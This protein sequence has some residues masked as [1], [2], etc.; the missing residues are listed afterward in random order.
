VGFE[1]RT[2]MDGRRELAR[3]VLE[4]ELSLSKACERMGVSRPTGYVWLRRAEAMG[5]E[6]ME[7][8][9]RRPHR[10]ARTTAEG[11]V[12][13]VL[14][15][16][17]QHPSWGAKKLLAAR[18]PEHE[19]MQA[20]ICVRTADRILERHGLVRKREKRP[21]KV[22]SFERRECNE[23]LQ[24]DFK[25]M[26]R[27]PHPYVPFTVVDDRSRYCLS[28]EPL[29]K[30]GVEGVWKVLWG[31]FGEYGVPESILSDNGNCFHSVR[32]RGPSRL[33][34]RLWLLGVRTI[35]GRRRHPQTQGKVERLHR[36]MNEE[37]PVPLREMSLE[38]A[39]EVLPGVVHAYNWERP[40]EALGMRVPGEVYTPSPRPRPQRLPAH[41]LPNSAT[42]RKVDCAGLVSYRGSTYRAGR[43]LAGEHVEIRE[44]RKG[45][46]IYYAGVRIAC[47]HT[48]EV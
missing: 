27:R 8:L 42:K 26:G 33:E 18:W 32:S 20:P 9:T 7:E 6:G 3:V 34:A 35:H 45:E 40:H 13:E 4:G 24:M 39:R 43:G 38:R 41:E 21:A 23:L 11:V 22:G 28:F 46:A 44:D 5:L 2:K 37:T 30:E 36:T 15:L 19:G 31:I 12:A 48:L 25:G 14:A 1:E 29:A 17:R 16:K 10:M 47:L